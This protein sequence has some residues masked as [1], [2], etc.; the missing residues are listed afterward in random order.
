MTRA[1]ELL[2]LEM[3]VKSCVSAGQ[4][5]RSTIE[6]C[7]RVCVCVCVVLQ[8]GVVWCSVVCGVLYCIVVYCSV[9]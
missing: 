3:A 8:C 7:V 2:I 6:V 1:C 9:V 5:G 4:L